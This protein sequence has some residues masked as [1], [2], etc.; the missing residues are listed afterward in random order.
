VESLRD[1]GGL[2]FLDLRDRHG[3]TQVVLDAAASAAAASV[4]GEFV[5]AVKGEVRAR[6][7]GMKNPK[8]PTGEVEVV[9]RE[10]VV[11]NPAMT[12][13][14]GV[15]ES[16]AEPNEETRLKFRYLDLRRRRMQRNLTARARVTGLIRDHLT[17]QGFLELE[18]PFLTKSTPEGARDFLVPARQHPGAF[19]ALPQS[20][21]LFKQL[22]MVSGYDRYYQVVRCMRDEDL[23]ADRQPEFTQLDIE[24]AFIEED[25]VYGLI[26]GLLARLFKDMLGLEISLPIRHL[27]YA[28]AV[29][30][31]GTDRPD[32]RFDLLLRDVSGAARRLD[33]QIFQSALA[34][35]GVVRGLCVPGGSAFSRKEIQECEDVVK[36]HGARGLVW[37][38]LEPDGAKGPLAKFLNAESERAFRDACSA[39]DGDLLLLV[40][41]TVAVA[42]KSLGELRLHLGR[43]LELA[44]PRRFDLLWITD[45]P[46]LEWSEE[47][48]KWNA[49]HHPFTSPW[50]E[51]LPL[52]EAEPGKVR[53]R[54]YDIV[55]NG[56]ELGGGSI[57][58]HSREVQAKVFSAIHLT[59]Q[60]ARGKF[61]FLLDA[62][63]Y[64]APPHG[65][66]ALGLDRLVMM[67]LGESSIRD[68]IAF[69]KT[70]RGNC[71]LTDA[72]SEVGAAQL[73]ELGL[74]VLQEGT[75]R[76]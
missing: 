32:T 12:L 62:L 70:A 14:F 3:L 25:D 39:S 60:E 63:G 27:S 45:F 56:V 4:R 65:G 21:Q 55:L 66:I 20:P 53:A 72:P 58:I 6:P 69:P 40:A 13:P 49:C 15:S 26:D 28:E 61:G 24:M 38:K 54:A 7:P 71:L 48:R 36:A 47:E 76:S 64:G 74:S 23:R 34:A 18:T 43:K 31:Y 9:A 35:S 46:L 41:A 10:F 52:L 2:R 16:E 5:V 22:Y 51:D 67:L 8:L 50:P 19:F 30:S 75:P 11:L 1:H 37:L 17:A 59:E 29:D 33:F 57:R 68:V 73:R 42:R 44:D